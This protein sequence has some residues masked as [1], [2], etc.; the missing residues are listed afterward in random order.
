MTEQ[1]SVS[2]GCGPWLSVAPCSCPLASTNTSFGI[3]ERIIP[4]PTYPHHH[5]HNH[6]H[7]H[8]RRHHHHFSYL[9]RVSG[10]SLHAPPLAR[11]FDFD[12]VCEARRLGSQADV[13]VTGALPSVDAFL[14]GYSACVFVYGQTG[15]GKVSPEFVF[16]RRVAV[17]PAR[18]AVIGAAACWGP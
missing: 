7:H 18:P 12:G 10:C 11:Y 6:H 3:H 5:H 13:Y 14:N 15:S 4:L 9:L 2:I 17:P 16:F 1:V 8:H